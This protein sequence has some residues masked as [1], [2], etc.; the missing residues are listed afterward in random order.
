MNHGENG[1]KLN[2]NSIP[3]TKEDV[4]LMPYIMTAPD[5]VAKASTDITGRESV[6]FY[7]TLS[8]GYVVVVE[9]EYKNSP[10]DMETITMWAELSSKATNAR[11][12]AAPDTHARNAI[13]DTDIAK[14]RIDAENAI[15]KQGKRCIVSPQHR[16]LLL[17]CRVCGAQYQAGEGYSRGTQSHSCRGN[18]RCRS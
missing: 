12:N 17:Q 15:E 7:K 18:R 9:K 14:I 8:N 6:R 5:E 3:L 16:H 4:E 13:L 1:R 11:Q 2:E 10:N